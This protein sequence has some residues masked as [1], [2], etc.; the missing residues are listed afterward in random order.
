MPGGFLL[1]APGI[2]IFALSFAPMKKILLTGLLALSHLLLLAQ[3]CD[4]TPPATLSAALAAA[5]YAFTGQVTAVE[6][7]WISGGWKYTFHVDSSWN[8]GLDRVMVVNTGW[9]ENCG[10]LFKTG[11]RYVVFVN[12]KFTAKTQGCSGNQVVTP[13]L[14]LSVLGP[15]FQPRRSPLYGPMIATISGLVG[16]FFL[17]MAFV[18]FGKKLR[19]AKPKK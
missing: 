11:Q 6:T 16:A 12:R 1:D 19:T 3:P 14:D 7:N 2:A 5:D 4:C 10:Y 8:R 18:L 9:E 17:F 13:E 15:G